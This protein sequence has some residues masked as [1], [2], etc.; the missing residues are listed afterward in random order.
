MP[1][2]AV[3]RHH[4]FITLHLCAFEPLSLYTTVTHQSIP[5]HIYI[6]TILYCTFTA[7]IYTYWNYT[8]LSIKS[9]LIFDIFPLM[10]RFALCIHC[11]SDLLY[12]SPF[13]LTL[14]LSSDTLI[15]SSTLDNTEFFQLD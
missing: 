10:Q 4:A 3:K 5:N 2:P 13:Q 11:S 12:G 1:C 14:L 8:N 7:Y 15:A 6:N 9:Q